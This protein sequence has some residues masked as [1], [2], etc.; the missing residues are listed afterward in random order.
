MDGDRLHLS[1]DDGLSL[2]A[3]SPRKPPHPSAIAAMP[4]RSAVAA[5]A[6]IVMADRLVMAFT[7]W[8]VR[9]P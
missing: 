5:P 4:M 9:I 7:F 1:L 8:S 3:A 6:A 2:A